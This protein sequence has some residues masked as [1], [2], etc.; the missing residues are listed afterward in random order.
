MEVMMTGKLVKNDEKAAQNTLMFV[1]DKAYF[2]QRY[3]T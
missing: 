1:G 2:S 3:I